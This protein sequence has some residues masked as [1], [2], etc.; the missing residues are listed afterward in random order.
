MADRIETFKGSRIQH[1]R[2]ND[3]VYVMHLDEGAIGDLLPF[4]D[5]LADDNG[6]GKIIAKIPDVCWP[7]FE[8]RGY[9]R[10][11]AI[12]EFF[13]G[14]RDALFVAKFLC[15]RRR[16]TDSAPPADERADVRSARPEKGGGPAAVAD[17]G[18]SDAEALSRIYRETFASYPFPIHRPGYLRQA[19]A[20]NVAYYGIHVNGHLAAAAAAEVDA[21]SRACEMTDFATLPAFRR[22]GFAGRLLTRMHAAVRSRGLRTAYTIARADS[23]GMNRIFRKSGYR[24]AGRLVNNTHIGGRIR[25]M[26]VWYRKMH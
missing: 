3:R 1:G 21:A 23:R 5:R 12:P 15:A 11:A 17:C 9:V 14:R 26:N 22:R 2:H 10:E 24:F 7:A 8:A 20:G 6:Y 13:D 19:M 16:E 25:S 18:P 4:L